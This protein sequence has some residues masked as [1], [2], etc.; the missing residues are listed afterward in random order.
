VKQEAKPVIKP[1]VKVEN[2]PVLSTSPQPKPQNSQ[3][4]PPTVETK[5]LV[6]NKTVNIK[7]ANS[8]DGDY[9]NRMPSAGDILDSVEEMRRQ[10]P[11]QKPNQNQQKPQPQMQKP[12]P[13]PN[14]PVPPVPQNTTPKPNIPQPNQQQRSG[15][16]DLR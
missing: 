8:D 3:P 7:R 6:A 5:P 4:V 15:D 12:N 14:Q 11:Q 1:E 16:L 2:K 10:R 13:V 9:I